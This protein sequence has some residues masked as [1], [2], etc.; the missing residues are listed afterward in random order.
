VGLEVM[1]EG[2]RAGTHWKAGGREFQIIGAATLKL[3]APDE[4]Q[5][6]WTA[7]RLVLDN[8]RE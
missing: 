1:A 6:N 4:V 2:V 8:L 5:R 3:R 7:R